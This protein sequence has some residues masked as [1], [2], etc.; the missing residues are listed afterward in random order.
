MIPDISNKHVV[1]IAIPGVSKNT[2][3]QQQK[4]SMSAKTPG[5]SKNIRHQQ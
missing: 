5:V 3:G 2:Q 1:P 4:H